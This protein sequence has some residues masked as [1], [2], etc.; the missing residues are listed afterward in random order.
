MSDASSQGKSFAIELRGL[1]HIPEN[2]RHGNPR[3]L[4]GMWMGGQFTYIS[5][6][7]GSIPVL[8]GLSWWQSFSA[9]IVGGLLGSIMVGLC[10]IH[11]PKTGTATIVN[12]RAVFGIKG[13]LLPEALNWI[14]VV[15]WAACNS[16]LGA[17][18]LTQLARMAGLQGTWV[19]AGSVLIVL[20]IQVLIAVFGYEAVLK[21]EK[22]FAIVSAA[23]ML[24]LLFFVGPKIDLGFVGAGLKGKAAVGTWLLA[25]AIIFTGPLSWV[26]Y[27]SDYTRYYP[28]STPIKGIILSAGAGM[29]IATLLSY[30][31]GAA[32]ATVVDMGDPVANLPQVLPAW[33]LAPFL[34]VVLWSCIANNVLNVYTAGLALLALHV[35]VKRWVSVTIIG[36]VAA[37]ACYYAIFVYNFVP[38]FQNFLLL[39]MEWLAP[40]SVLM[41]VDYALRRGEYDAE[42]LHDWGKGSYWYSNGINWRGMF[43]LLAS[44]AVALPFANSALLATKLATET[45][46]GA[47]ISFFVG[48]AAAALLYVT[49]GRPATGRTRR[50]L[51][52]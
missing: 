41:L 28:K 12:T 3:E 36:V 52:R 11:G 7:I 22:I 31:L 34:F 18:A 1:E 47:D 25:V 42:A 46:G 45:L 49:F 33:Y 4:F 32:L 5:L 44:V 51:A 35:K 39:Q 40:W 27:A 16:V 26:N 24:G 29:F 19:Q 38:M 20:G 8:L 48:M 15:G 9:I 17:M 23:L 21:S 30:P 6:V 43:V 13:N 10:G 50:A 37:I 14:T 2:E